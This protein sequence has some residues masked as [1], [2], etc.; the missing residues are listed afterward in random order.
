M[1]LI[2]GCPSSVSKSL[3]ILLSGT[4]TPMVIS[5][6]ERIKPDKTPRPQFTHVNDVVPTIYEI[7]DIQAPK[8]VDGH[9][10]DPIDGT[11]LVYT[12]DSATAPVVR[13]RLVRSGIVA[14]ALRGERSPPATA[15]DF[16]E[17]GAAGRFI[18]LTP[19]RR[20]RTRE[21]PRRN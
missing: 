14:L 1:L 9:K 16:T 17:I 2:I 5:W 11:S 8:V 20:P 19:R 6:P 18:T 12:F 7:L 13:G 15:R 4:R 10:Q 21:A 3:T